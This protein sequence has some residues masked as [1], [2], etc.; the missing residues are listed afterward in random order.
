MDTKKIQSNKSKHRFVVRNAIDLGNSFDML[1]R[2]NLLRLMHLDCKPALGD[3]EDWDSETAF[4]CTVDLLEKHDVWCDK[5][6]NV[7][8]DKRE[9][10]QNLLDVSWKTTAIEKMDSLLTNFEQCDCGFQKSIRTGKCAH[11]SRTHPREVAN[12]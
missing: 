7:R 8:F 12:G 5:S 10:I 9:L 6:E 3:N 11:C 2:E 4:Y 1:F